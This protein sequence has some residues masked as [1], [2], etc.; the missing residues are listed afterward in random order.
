VI[1]DPTTPQEHLDTAA[2]LLSEATRSASG[3]P[4]SSHVRALI[5][6]EHIYHAQVSAS[7]GLEAE[8][9]RMTENP[10]EMRR[11]REWV[12]AGRPDADDYACEPCSAAG[13][14]W[15]CHR[16]LRRNRHVACDGPN[17]PH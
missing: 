8:Y 17:V 6:R 9:R 13:Q 16:T 15:D 5:A 1:T 2:T 14:A 4:R 11:F 7:I 10:A 3:D 12:D